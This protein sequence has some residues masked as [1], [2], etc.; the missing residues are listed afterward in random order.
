MTPIA[1]YYVMVVSDRNAA[2]IARPLPDH[3]APR[4]RSLLERI[5]DALENLVSRGRPTSTQP[6]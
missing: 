4:R 1:A 6:I 3:A 5:A 2:V